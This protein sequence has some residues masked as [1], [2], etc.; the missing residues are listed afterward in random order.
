MSPDEI[1]QFL[2]ESTSVEA[3]VK[4]AIG[5]GAPER[6]GPTNTSH[7][8]ISRSAFIYTLLDVPIPLQMTETLKKGEESIQLRWNIILT[9]LGYHVNVDEAK[10]NFT[11]VFPDAVRRVLGG[12]LYDPSCWKQLPFASKG[13]RLE[14]LGLAAALMRWDDRKDGVPPFPKWPNLKFF[15]NDRPRIDRRIKIVQVCDWFFLSV[16]LQNIFPDR[17]LF[18]STR[19]RSKAVIR[20]DLKTMNRKVRPNRIAVWTN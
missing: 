18:P 7:E 3:E 10:A 6:L 16:P 14:I 15:N 11:V 19:P 9:Q 4:L 2:T 20:V 1:K 8:G 17:E 12:L 13:K 5:V